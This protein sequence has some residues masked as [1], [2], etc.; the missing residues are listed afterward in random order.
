MKGCKWRGMLRRILCAALSVCVCFAAGCN[1]SANEP[2]PEEEESF[3]GPLIG[4]AMDSFVVER[5]QR[6]CDVFVSAAQELGAQVIIQNANEDAEE[7]IRQI[8][9]LISK[10]VDV[11][12]VIPNDAQ[13]LTE[14][15][16]EAVAQGIKIIAYDRL[17]ENIP[18]DLYISFDHVAV[19]RIMARELLKKVPEGNYVIINGSLRDNNVKQLKQGYDE[20]LGRAA[21]VTVAEEYFC[22]NWLPEEGAEFF[23]RLLARGEKIDA[24]LCGNDAVARQIIKILSEN[25]LADEIPVVAQD[26][27]LSA[28]QSVAEGVQLA[29]VYKNITL[30]ARKSAEL[31]VQLAA[32]RELSC[33][34]TIENGAGAVPFYKIEPKPVTK[35]TIMDTVIKDGFHRVEDVYRNVPNP[36][37][38]KK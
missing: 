37:G 12:V 7:Q 21:G 3:Q 13:K 19:G 25:R 24:V 5:W 29:T 1:R 34:E 20:V 14:V 30:L 10:Q 22:E 28:C 27:E 17:I 31:A 8:R 23:S 16:K 33:E 26:A 36:P 32:G 38:V 2:P 15:L 4:V 6:E 35:D 9:Y 18:I 11:L